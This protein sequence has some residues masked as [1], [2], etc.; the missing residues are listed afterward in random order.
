MHTFM[1]SYNHKNQRSQKAVIKR[2]DLYLMMP[3]VSQFFFL[4]KKM[5]VVNYDFGISNVC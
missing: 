1:T 2:I 3:V 4:G 5:I